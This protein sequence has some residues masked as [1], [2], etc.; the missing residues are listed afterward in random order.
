V[1]RSEERL[2]EMHVMIRM[3]YQPTQ[4]YFDI[5]QA[6]KALTTSRCEERRF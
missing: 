4:N 3:S 6:E 1:R 5:S 2:G